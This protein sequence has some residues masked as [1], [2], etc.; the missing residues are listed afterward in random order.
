MRLSGHVARMGEA[1]NAY[2]ILVG[3][4]EGERLCSTTDLV[5]KVFTPRLVI[6]ELCSVSLVKEDEVGMAC[7]TNGGGEECI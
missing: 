5:V 7:S 6:F 1:R 2:R 3:K 4:P